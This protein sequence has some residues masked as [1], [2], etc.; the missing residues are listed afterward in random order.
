MS[1]TSARGLAA[2]L[3]LEC[4]DV[5]DHT[6]RQLRPEH[7]RPRTLSQ[8]AAEF[9]LPVHGEADDVEVTGVSQ[10]S[11]SVLPGDL[12]LALPGA[13]FHGA[14]FAAEAVAAGAAAIVTD[15]EGARRAEAAGVSVPVLL[16][17]DPR[18]AAGELAAWVYRTGEAELDVFG[19]TGT[20]G[21]TSVVY[22]L[23][24]L[25]DALGVECAL[26]STAE[27]RVGDDVLTS[28]LTTPEA[29]EL[30]AL[31]ARAAERSMRAAA[32][33]V[34]AQ[35]VTRRRIDGIRFDVVGF[36]NF[37]HDHLDDYPDMES[38]FAAKSELFGPDWADRAVVA[39]DGEW[40]MRLAQDA[41][42]PVTTV[43]HSADTPADWHVRIVER[44]L[45]RT[46]FELHGPENRIMRASV[47]LYGEFMAD[48]AALAIVMLVSAGYDP[49][50][51]EHA[52]SS[53]DPEL[54]GLID[55]Y[56][57]GRGEIVSG[58]QGPQLV[59]DYGHTPDAFEHSLAALR[60]VVPGRI[61]MLFGADGDRDRS[62]R[63]RMGEIAALGADTVIVC[64]YHPRTEDPAAIRAAVLAGA[65][66]ARPDGDI[67]EV[68]D[69]RQALRLAISLAGPDDV[70]FYAGPGHED[71]Q[72]VDGRHLPYSARDEARLA[73][74]EAGLSR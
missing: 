13:R 43:A 60:G 3:R 32:I 36:T 73:L 71:Y 56:I 28:G 27:R 15:E 34:S 4:C 20:N 49:E 52:L 14:D 19:V 29:A 1:G 16:T 42:V 69:P 22:I 25:L 65:R 59:I 33:E 58:E 66:A 67:R 11:A 2:E 68:P 47:P 24:A 51:I 41:R 74:R 63:G 26:S 72:E 39:V 12:Y 37:G 70:V 57:P 31:L 9:G 55:V 6:A 10:S 8:L 40:G 46:A 18:G 48:N 62:K 61:I 5:S 38:Y 50:A 7:P 21:K 30:H 53:E 64:D 17:A 35:A 45:R 54:D 23:A 44:T